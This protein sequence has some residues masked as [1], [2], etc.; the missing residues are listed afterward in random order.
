MAYDEILIV[1]YR[2]TNPKV[3]IVDGASKTRCEK[4]R[5]DVWIAP[6][7]RKVREKTG[8]KVVCEICVRPD[9]PVSDVLPISNEQ[10][11][12]IKDT[13]ENRKRRN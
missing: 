10:I 3:L 6:S 7:S 5:Q 12:E 1:C 2:T 13:L 8:A 11:V 4:C 9:V